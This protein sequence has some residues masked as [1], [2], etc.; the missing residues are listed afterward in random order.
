[1]FLIKRN[2]IRKINLYPKNRMNHTQDFVNDFIHFMNK[3]VSAF[4]A[5][6]CVSAM[7]DTQG[8]EYLNETNEWTLRQGGKYY[9]TRNNSTIV[10]FTV[11]GKYKL[12]NGFTSVGAHTDSPCL[13]LKPKTCSVKAG[14]LV[15]NTQPYGGGLWHVSACI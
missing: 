3:S 7:L 5:V 15:L 1:M 14:A 9:F 13:R 6:T 2:I 4:H 12:G 8:F 10:A 11:G